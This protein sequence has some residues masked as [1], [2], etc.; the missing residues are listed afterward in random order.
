MGNA[1]FC[2][3]GRL[4]DL[5][6]RVRARVDRAAREHRRAALGRL[7]APPPPEFHIAHIHKDIYGGLISSLERNG[8]RVQVFDY[9]WRRSNVDNARRLAASLPPSRTTLICQ[10]N[11]GYMCRWL[12]KYGDVSLEEAERG[13]RRPLPAIDRVVLLGTSNG[14]ALRILKKLHQGRQYIRT[15]G[16]RWRPETIFTFPA[17]FKDLPAYRAEF[18]NVDANLFQADDWKRFRW[19][20][21]APAAERRL[22]R[23]PPSRALLRNGE[24]R[25]TETEPGDMHATAASQEALGSDERA[26]LAEPTIHVH[27]PHFE[28]ITTELTLGVLLRIIRAP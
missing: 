28:M 11:A 24:T 17:I 10:S 21:Y 16:R 18:F 3:T 20:V 9:D 13:L 1:L 25:F 23:A 22:A 8:V 14:G 5:R 15:V 26:A 12:A 4:S 2:I 7:D 19:S 6:V 27:G